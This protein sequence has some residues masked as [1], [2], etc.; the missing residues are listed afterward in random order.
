MEVERLLAVADYGED[1]EPTDPSHHVKSSVIIKAEFDDKI[2][3]QSV[4]I[5][6]DIIFLLSILMDL[7]FWLGGSF[8]QLM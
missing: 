1:F 7:L 2:K 3:V 5:L 8:S 4:I 6:Y